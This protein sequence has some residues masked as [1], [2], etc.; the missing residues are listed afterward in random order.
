M[1]PMAIETR[2]TNATPD[3]VLFLSHALVPVSQI[4]ASHSNSIMY[5]PDTYIH[6]GMLK[7]LEYNGST[8][9][10]RNGSANKQRL[11]LAIMFIT[12]TRSA[13]A[14]MPTQV[15]QTSTLAVEK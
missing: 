6:I 4:L 12:P 14:T 8:N 3:F 15:A 5:T 10:S 13:I 2:M 1:I 11:K 7:V 9:I